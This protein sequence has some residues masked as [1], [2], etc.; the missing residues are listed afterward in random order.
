[1]YRVLIYCDLKDFEELFN[2]MAIE[3][4]QTVENE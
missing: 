3:T 4:Y 1:M 2:L